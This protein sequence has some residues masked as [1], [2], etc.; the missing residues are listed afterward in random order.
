[1]ISSFYKEYE[2]SQAIEK[3]YIKSHDIVESDIYFE[4]LNISH[5][6]IHELNNFVRKQENKTLNDGYRKTSVRV[7]KLQENGK[8]MIFWHAPEPQD[9]K[10]FM[11][12]FIKIY[13]QCNT[14]L[15]DSNPFLKSALCHLLFVRI[16]P[17]TDG[18][19]RT[20]RLIHNI[21]FTDAIN[22]VHGIK[23][24]LCPLNLSASIL[25]N[26]PTYAKRINSIYFDMENDTNAEI[27]R[28]FDFILNM[29]DEQI[30]YNSNR[31]IE[32]EQSLLTLEKMQDTDSSF[33]KEII[34][35]MKLKRFK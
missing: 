35:K 5:N 19:G 18:N 16:H 25:V 13:K 33:D 6:R 2:N 15:L 21:K 7:S 10:Q 29:F 11:D 30:Y 8:E 22:R 34:K 27:N 14:S 17:Y 23:L 28:W 20:A 12:S 3:H 32:F 4:R 9:V 26:K 31:I 1:M 24:K